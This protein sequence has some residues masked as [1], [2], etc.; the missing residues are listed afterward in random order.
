[1]MKW[2]AVVIP[3]SPRSAYVKHEKIEVAMTRL[4]M[5][6]L[7]SKI[8]VLG[9]C[10]GHHLITIYLGGADVERRNVCYL[11]ERVKVEK[12]IEG[13]YDFLG[14]CGRKICL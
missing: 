14:S 5:A 3:G 2:D 10:F 7:S 11:L 9:V 13:P 6:Y 12:K 4:N 8:K 1:M